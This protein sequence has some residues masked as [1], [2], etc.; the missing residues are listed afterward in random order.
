VLLDHRGVG[1]QGQRPLVAPNSKAAFIHLSVCQANRSM[2]SG[3]QGSLPCL[4]RITSCRT[5]LTVIVSSY[6][7]RCPGSGLTKVVLESQA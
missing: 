7:L 4:A 5:L 2:T 6:L 3:V 1:G